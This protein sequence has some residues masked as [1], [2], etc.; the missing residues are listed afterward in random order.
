MSLSKATISQ[1]KRRST[2]KKIGI[3]SNLLGAGFSYKEIAAHL[4]K[5]G[6]KTIRWNRRYKAAYVER[7]FLESV[8]NQ[9]S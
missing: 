2:T 8:A 9:G 4:D 1:R 3:I 7:E 6:F 5:Y